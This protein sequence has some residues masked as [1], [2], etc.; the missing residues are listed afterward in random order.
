[1]LNSNAGLANTLKNIKAKWQPKYD[2]AT[3]DA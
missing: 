1:V 3:T 2:A